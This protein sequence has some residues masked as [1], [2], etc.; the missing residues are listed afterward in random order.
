MKDAIQLY[1]DNCPVSL[2]QHEA[3]QDAIHDIIVLLKKGQPVSIQAIKTRD[4]VFGASI[5][6]AIQCV[7]E[8]FEAEFN[9]DVAFETLTELDEEAGFSRGE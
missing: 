8:D 7:V 5:V 1:E 3:I 4:S 6:E 9:S 2:C